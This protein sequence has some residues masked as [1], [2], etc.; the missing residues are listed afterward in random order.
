VDSEERRKRLAKQ[1]VSRRAMARGVVVL[2][3]NLFGLEPALRGRNIVVVKPASGMSDDLI[4]EQLLSH[5]I[6]I[7]KNPADFIDDAPVY[8]Y[9]IIALDK[10]SFIDTIPDSKKNRTVQL[11]STALSR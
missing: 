11:I 4:K 9:G 8:E 7:T 6:F 5:R 2:D 10:L 1:I 3:E